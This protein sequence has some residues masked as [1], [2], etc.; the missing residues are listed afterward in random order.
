MFLFKTDF[1]FKGALASVTFGIATFS[2]VLLFWST[3][4][5][6]VLSGYCCFW[7]QLLLRG[8]I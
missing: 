2:K 1:Y 3:F 7:E 4:N 5:L 6:N 8:S